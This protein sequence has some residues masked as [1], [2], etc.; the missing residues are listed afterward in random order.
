[1]LN[2]ICGCGDCVKMLNIIYVCGDF[3]VTDNKSTILFIG[4][5]KECKEWVDKHT[6]KCY[7]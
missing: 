5:E 2:I 1:M 7:Y 3:M 4:T 6:I